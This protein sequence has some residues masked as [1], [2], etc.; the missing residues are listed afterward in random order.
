MVQAAW[1]YD[2]IIFVGQNLKSMKILFIVMLLLRGRTI[3]ETLIE[4]YFHLSHGA[5][6]SRRFV[7]VNSFFFLFSWLF[8]C[9]ETIPC[10]NA[11]SPLFS[12][13]DVLLRSSVT[14]D[15]L[16]SRSSP[17]LQ[18]SLKSCQ[19]WFY[20]SA[21]TYTMVSMV[22]QCVLSTPVLLPSNPLANIGCVT[23]YN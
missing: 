20:F 21:R 6:Y 5:V 15:C 7:Y 12:I 14:L 23:E 3:Q 17:E 2:P 11:I 18:S 9:H 19:F 10:C 22:F 1:R 4:S 16:R 8:V 13:N